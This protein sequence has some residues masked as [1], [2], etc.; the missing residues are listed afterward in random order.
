M[1]TRLP[2]EVELAYEVMSCQAVRIAQEPGKT[3]HPCSYFRRWGTYHS[4]D[5]LLYT[6]PSPR[7]RS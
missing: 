2:V 6:S 1:E 3:P 4:Y 7:D 5:C